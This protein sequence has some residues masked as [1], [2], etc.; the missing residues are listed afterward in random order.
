MRR[1]DEEP[2][3]FFLVKSMSK[4]SSLN[5]RQ[6]LMVKAATAAALGK[7]QTLEEFFRS[8]IVRNVPRRALEEF[9]IHLSLILGFPAMLDALERLDR[10]ASLRVRRSH[11]PAVRRSGRTVLRRIYGNQ[12][13]KLLKNL[14][15]LHPEVE[16]WIV[17]DVYGRVISRPGL[18][19]RD[20]EL[21]N[22]A[23]LSLQGLERQLYS[24][25]RGALR[26]GV[27]PAQ[28]DECLRLV[29]R[30]SNRSP[31][32]ARTMLRQVVSQPRK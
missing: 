10:V 17:S 30:V 24:H 20:R 32:R 19:L 16:R 3:P 21:I 7:R 31:S 25:L 12:T 5:S 4:S 29:S 26:T 9:C 28:L 8:A 18:S 14:R 1:R 27:S 2:R 13:D 11:V 15:R 22:V 6:R 23:V